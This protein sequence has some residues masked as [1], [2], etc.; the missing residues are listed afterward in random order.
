MNLKEAACIRNFI[1]HG[2]Q[3]VFEIVGK[4]LVEVR[5]RGQMQRFYNDPDSMTCSQTSFW[6]GRAVYASLE[7]PLF[8]D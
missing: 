4:T 2:D 6:P 8:D 5:Q 7:K 3:T 1:K